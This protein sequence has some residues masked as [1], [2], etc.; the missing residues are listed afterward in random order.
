MTDSYKVF[1]NMNL[2]RKVFFIYI[3]CILIP[4]VLLG[5]VVLNMSVSSVRQHQYENELRSVDALVDALSSHLSQVSATSYYFTESLNIEPMLR[6][7]YRSK[8]DAIYHYL[9]DVE[10]LLDAARLNTYVKTAHLFGLKDYPL[11]MDESKNGFSSIHRSTIDETYQKEIKSSPDGLWTLNITGENQA[12]L[13]HYKYIFSDDYPYDI[14]IVKLEADLADLISSVFTDQQVYMRYLSEDWLMAVEG[15][16]IHISDLT[17]DELMRTHEWIFKSDIQGLPLTVIS[18]LDIDVVLRAQFGYVIIG[19]LL[20]LFIFSSLYFFFINSIIRRLS[21]FSR[22][23]QSSEVEALGQYENNH[24]KDEIGQ[25]IDSYNTLISR[26]NQLIHENYRMQLQNKDAR[27]YALQAQIKPHFLFNVL[28]NIR[29]SSDKHQD[30][31]TSSMIQSLGEFIRYN[32]KPDENIIPL[33]EELKHA[34]TFLKIHQIRMGDNLTYEIGA[35][36]EIG[37][38]FCPRFVIQPLIENSLKHGMKGRD[39]IHITVKVEAYDENKVKVTV[40]DD[41]VGMTSN[42]LTICMSN[43][44]A[45]ERYHVGLKNVDVRLKAF[46]NDGDKGLDIAS[47]KDAGT[48]VTFTLDRRQR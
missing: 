28:E 37:D 20:V 1:M 14:G 7:E 40:L 27:F 11:N 4:T 9:K 23:I 34:R 33:Y 8:A 3:V 13:E 30:E 44:T 16:D 48:T 26:V 43:K 18:P 22:H 19:I 38:V 15:D 39:N 35:L 36:T 29:M 41:G 12:V 10:P 5:A 2:F 25:T 24:Y 45:G 46:S 42:E 17:L 21:Q 31:I 47:I 6:G 32:L